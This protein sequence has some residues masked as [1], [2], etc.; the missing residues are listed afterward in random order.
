MSR[1][2]AR[3]LHLALVLLG[4]V[5]YVVFVLPRWW[6]LTGD[7]PATLATAGRIATGFPVALAALPVLAILRDALA[8]KTRTPELALRLRAWSAVLHVAAGALILLAAIVEIWLR[9]EVGGPY[10]FAVYGA[11]GAVAVLGVLGLYLSF[12]AE[13]PPAAPREPKAAKPAK[14]KKPRPEKKPR[15]KKRSA[16]ESAAE[17][18]ASA[19]IL[20][21]DED[22]DTGTADDETDTGTAAAEKE[23]VASSG[24]VTVE[25]TAPDEDAA[26]DAGEQDSESGGLRNKRPAGKRRRLPGR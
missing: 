2:N 22:T 12:V 19:T 10:L 23:T 6:V 5:L 11:A 18:V 13:K 1:R 15:G 25:A 17:S 16:A 8:R 20:T 14:L 7:I 9:L 3:A 21:V 26:A 4:L 24:N